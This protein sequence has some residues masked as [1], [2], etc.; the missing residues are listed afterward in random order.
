MRGGEGPAAAATML[1]ADP[2]AEDA[3]VA[4]LAQLDSQTP[5]ILDFDETYWLRNSTEMF[6]SG[7]RPA[8]LAAFVLRLIE[9]LRP[10]RFLPGYDKDHVWR[11]WS[12]VNIVILLFPWSLAAWRRRAVA[13][14][15]RWLNPT[16][17]QL[18]ERVPTDRR[19][20]VSNGFRPIVAPLVDALPAS[21]R[22]ELLASPLLRGFAWRRRG[23]RAIVEDALGA[24]T[25]A[26]AVVVTDNDEDA[27]LLAAAGH[28]VH[29]K[30]PG[31][32]YEPAHADAYLPFYYMERIK[33]PGDGHLLDVVVKDELILLLLVYL[34]AS[35]SLAVLLAILVLHASFWVIYEV[36]YVENDR[37]GAAFEAE[38]T[39]SSAYHD[40]PHRFSEPGAWLLGLGLGALGVLILQLAPAGTTTP[41]LLWSLTLWAGLLG[42]LRALAYLYNHVDKTTRVS[43]YLP[44]QALKLLGLALLLPLPL[45][46]TPLVA[47]HLASLWLPYIAYRQPGRTREAWRAPIQLYRLV[48]AL[49]FGVALGLAAWS[50]AAAA[51]GLDG[52][53]AALLAVG[54]AWFALK[55]RG[56]LRTLAR[57]A[58]WL[59]RK[60]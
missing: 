3:P 12:R 51:N 43:L 21:A 4:L 39:L 46:A 11:D 59:R 53:A 38:P 17:A 49:V 29:H 5:L 44:L 41:G 36:L 27:E 2:A 34:W 31:A 20:I 60:D 19:W 25:L 13:L 47:A 10:W 58:E 16:L 24:A 14:G 9:V 30:W 15:P 54:L 40:T 56:D 33:R 8:W 28:P 6:L 45:A 42:V 55:A 23:K 32:R 7:V 22:L 1:G 26:K 18:V 37:V 35:P 50:P 52:S 48:L 57:N